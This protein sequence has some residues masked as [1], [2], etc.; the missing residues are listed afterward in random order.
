MRPPGKSLIL[1]PGSVCPRATLELVAG[2]TFSSEPVFG[3]SAD[4]IC[5]GKGRDA[6]NWKKS[7]CGVSDQSCQHSSQ[8]I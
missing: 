1:E 8:S 4:S 2:S 7:N 5:F 6:G 3:S